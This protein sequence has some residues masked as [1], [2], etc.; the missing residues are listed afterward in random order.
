MPRL[1]CHYLHS[2]YTFYET[3]QHKT[4]RI[5]A[6]WY[7]KVLA[8]HNRVAGELMDHIARLGNKAKAAEI[9][10]SSVVAA[11]RLVVLEEQYGGQAYHVKTH[12]FFGDDHC[13]DYFDLD[14][15]KEFDFDLGKWYFYFYSATCY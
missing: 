11:E 2:T 5:V 14:E 8:I 12:E 6:Y 3:F 15:L 4:R 9:A 7:G 10:A 13:H 1:T